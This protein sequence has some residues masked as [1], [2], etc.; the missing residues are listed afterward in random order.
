MAVVS[1]SLP[2]ALLQQVDALAT[3]EGYGGRSELTR[4]ALRD[5]LGA[6]DERQALATREATVTLVYAHGQER[7]FSAIRH[8][9]LDVVRSALHIHAGAR[10]VE[11]FVLSGASARV[12][13]FVGALRASRDALRVHVAYTDLGD[14][15]GEVVD[16][17]G[18]DH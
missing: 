9:H 13:S 5:L 12:R 8:A 18:H 10:C 3:R 1:I 11:L 15:P 7:A 6:H 14:H 16:R 4:A 2:D 17:G